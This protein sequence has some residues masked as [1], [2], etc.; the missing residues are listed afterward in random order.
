MSWKLFAAAGALAFVV[1]AAPAPADQPAPLSH[2]ASTPAVTLAFDGTADTQTVCWGWGGGYYAGYGGYYGGYGGYCGG[3]GGYGGYGYAPYYGYASYYSYRP[4]Y[5]GYGYYGGY[6][7]YYSYGYYGGYRPYY[8]GYRGYGYWGCSDSSDQGACTLRAD[9]RPETPANDQ[10]LLVPQFASP[11]QAPAPDDGTFRYDG[12]PANPVPAPSGD[13]P[14]PVQQRRV[15][16][17]PAGDLLVMLPVEGPRD[18]GFAYPAYGETAPPARQ[19]PP[20][21]FAFPAYGESGATGFAVG[22]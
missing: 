11:Q 19:Q 9:L 8:G 10:Q 2:D 6:R 17:Q 12:G 15:R 21:N 18:S 4:Y 16:L 14:A 1:G 20:R 22:R 13:T 7:P 3:Y 5:G